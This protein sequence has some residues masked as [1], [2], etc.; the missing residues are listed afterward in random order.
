MNLIAGGLGTGMFSLPASIAGCSVISGSLMTFAVVTLNA[1][2]IMILIRAADMHQVFDLGTLVGLLPGQLLPGALGRRLPSLGKF[3]QSF[4]NVMVWG[5]LF[6]S[7]ISYLI[8]IHDSIAPFVEHTWLGRS[9]AP[10]VTIA[11]IFVLLLCFLKQEY[12]SW[13]SM[14]AVLVNVYLIVVLFIEFGKKASKQDLPEDVC[15]LGIGRGTASMLAV[16]AQCII[17]QM[18]VLPMYEE[19]KDRSPK[20]FAQCLWSAF[21]SLAVIFSI[22]ASLGY[23][24]YGPD[25]NGNVLVS[26]T[27]G[28]LSDVAQIGTVLV[29]AA[30]Y[31]LMV[32]PMVA[33]VRNMQLSA[34]LEGKR[35]L[36]VTVTICVITLIAYAGALLITSLKI[37]N[38]IDGAICVGTFTALA[39]GLVGLHLINKSGLAW[40]CLMFA[41]LALGL[42][43]MVL[44]I[45][46]SESYIEDLKAHCVI[47]A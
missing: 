18:C 47:K 44:G 45:V 32:I 33:P 22:F 35:G 41:L 29:V 17:I 37:V 13:T 21:G 43:N 14:I 34:S 28:P 12:L 25:V 27:S 23:M 4:L 31:P 38:V 3:M 30:I 10:L 39:P 20:R 6:G 7:L 42:I 9:R 5:V 1:M 24:T 2:T 8:V 26:F 46:M 15:L 19:L 11:A 40:K 36:I 16:L